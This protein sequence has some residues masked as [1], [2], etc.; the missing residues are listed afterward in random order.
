MAQLLSNLIGNALKFS[1]ERARVE[2][3]ATRSDEG[4]LVSV[5]DNGPGIPREHLPHLFEPTW[6]GD[7][8]GGSG[9]GIGLSIARSIV[10][11][12]DG[13]IWAESTPGRGTTVKFVL[14]LSL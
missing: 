1:R 4:V 13:R 11:A 7:A 5:E 2:V 6:R 10:E 3:R 9:T 8:A 14:P 12:H